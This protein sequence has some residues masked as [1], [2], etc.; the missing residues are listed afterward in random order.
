MIENSEFEVLTLSSDSESVS[1]GGPDSESTLDW[2]PIHVQIAAKCSEED[3]PSTAG[4]QSG[5]RNIDCPYLSSEMRDPF[6]V[7][8]KVSPVMSVFAKSCGVRTPEF[9]QPQARA[10]DLGSGECSDCLESPLRS[11]TADIQAGDSLQIVPSGS[12]APCKPINRVS[13]LK[14]V[15]LNTF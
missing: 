1:E 9:I 11:R 6:A 12:S 4:C 2:E 7:R 10:G 14:I 3:A 13:L 15:F 8:S 5:V